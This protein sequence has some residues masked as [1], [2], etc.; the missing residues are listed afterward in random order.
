MRVKCYR[1]IFSMGMQKAM[2]YRADF[3]LSLISCVFPIIMQAYLWTALFKV[4]A[5]D[6]NGY[7]YEQMILYTLLAG[8]TSRIVSTGFE[9]DVAKDI[10]NGELSRYLVKTGELWW[11]LFCSI[12]WGKGISGLVS[13]NNYSCCTY[14]FSSS[15]GNCG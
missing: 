11:I 10:K 15:F 5:A 2:T 1:C 7:T 12:H 4:G 8:V 3:F 14:G 6:T 13:S 9:L